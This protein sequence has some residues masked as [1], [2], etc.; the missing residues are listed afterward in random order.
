MHIIPVDI[1]HRSFRSSVFFYCFFLFDAVWVSPLLC[2]PACWSI[3]AHSARS[4]FP[5]LYFS[6]AIVFFSSMTSVWYFLMFHFSLL[7]FSLFLCPFLSSVSIFM[8]ITLIPYQV[9]YLSPYRLG[10]FLVFCLAFICNAFLSP[11]L[12]S[13]LVSTCWVKRPLL[14]EWPWEGDDLSPSGSPDSPLSPKP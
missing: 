7:R 6:F 3:L 2:P 9:D 8:T 14:V 4:W 10:L 13:V 5:L 11:L 12:G 1:V